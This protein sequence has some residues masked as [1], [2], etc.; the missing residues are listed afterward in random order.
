MSRP[1]AGEPVM[2]VRVFFTADD[3]KREREKLVGV[4][5]FRL[6]SAACEG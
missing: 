2:D 4:T 3:E 5:Q 1:I 6:H